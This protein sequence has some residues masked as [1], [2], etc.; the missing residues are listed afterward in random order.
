[1]PCSC[2]VEHCKQSSR[3]RAFWWHAT[4]VCEQTFT[5]QILQ[6]C[7]VTYSLVLMTHSNKTIGKKEHVINK[8]LIKNNIKLKDST[9]GIALINCVSRWL[10]M[11]HFHERHCLTSAEHTDA[12]LNSPNVYLGEI[13]IFM[14]SKDPQNIWY[15]TQM[16]PPKPSEITL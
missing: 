10:F 11:R 6:C 3:L 7:F 2:K 12:T 8:I 14:S 16:A 1:M 4:A 15:G 13:G 9:A 5:T